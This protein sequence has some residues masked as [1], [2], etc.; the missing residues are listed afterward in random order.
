MDYSQ[1][2]NNLAPASGLMSWASPQ[3]GW[4]TAGQTATT[5]IP[6]TGVAALQGRTEGEGGN[7]DGYSAPSNQSTGP[8]TPGDKQRAGE[9]MGQLGSYAAGKIGN[10]ALDALGAT[11]MGMSPSFGDV[12][13]SVVQSVANPHG[14]AGLMGRVAAQQMGFDGPE[15][16]WAKTAINIAN[17]VIGG[18]LSMANPALGIAYGLASPFGI[19][20]IADA[21][22]ARADEGF[23][24][25]AEDAHGPFGGRDISKDISGM[26]GRAG[27]S[28]MGHAFGN[29]GLGP[30]DVARGM[31]NKD[32]SSV[33]RGGNPMGGTYG[34]SRGIG[35][36]NAVG[37]PMGGARS[38]DSSYGA[39]EGGFAGL[40]IGNP[41]SYG[42]SN[43]SDGR[44]G[45]PGRGGRGDSTGTGGGYGDG[46][47]GV[48]GL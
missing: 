30:A 29:Q 25:A 32:A 40:G 35:F 18:L 9:V 31:T 8:Q 34:A 14:V 28:S 3:W 44:G 12:M 42:G 19:D 4:G 27:F 23:K 26:V 46:K 36:S 24:D 21:F 43:S 37:G 13:G 33:A 10:T 45:G 17:P 1:A 6:Q 22:D 48:S 16:G 38:V 41:S 11:A 2:W 39:N 47:G 5:P 7:G 15:A 20:A